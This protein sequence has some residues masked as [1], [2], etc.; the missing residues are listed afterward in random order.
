VGAV[1][2][3]CL[4]AK[5]FKCNSCA[6]GYD[7][8]D[9][10]CVKRRCSCA[11]GIGAE[12]IQ[13]PKNIKHKC[14]SCNSGAYLLKDKTC[15]VSNQKCLLRMFNS[16]IKEKLYVDV[17]WKHGYILVSRRNSTR[18][19][20]K[21]GDL[22]IKSYT[23]KTVYNRI[24]ASIGWV[25]MEKTCSPSTQWEPGRCY[26]AHRNRGTDFHYHKNSGI[27]KHALGF[28]NFD[29]SKTRFRKAKE[30]FNGQWLIKTTLKRKVFGVWP[31]VTMKYEDGTVETF[32]LPRK[33]WRRW[34]EKYFR[35]ET[36][37]PGVAVGGGSAKL[38]VVDA[39]CD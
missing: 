30:W 3:D 21:F 34:Y 25:P 33:A 5:T 39:E 19:V 38:K 28:W 24:I 17:T 13:C 32:P 8:K 29:G 6:E 11:N 26:D 16:L 37:V 4:S 18:S 10:Q 36:L 27:G 12:G 35:F 31:K 14:V 20:A 9:G 23:I 2:K 1:D 7:L 22:T 15:K